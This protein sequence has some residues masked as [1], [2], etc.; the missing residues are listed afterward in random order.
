MLRVG[1]SRE[2]V[3]RCREAA[4]G[5]VLCLLGLLSVACQTASPTP[6][7]TPTPTATL[8][9]THTQSPTPTN[10]PPPTAT[11]TPG[12][13]QTPTPTPGPLTEAEAIALVKEE[14]VAHGVDL[15]T[16]N[17]TIAG[18]P[19]SVSI[20]YA[21]AYAV[22][23][24]AFEP[25]TVLVALAAARTLVRVQPPIIGG[26]R[27]AVRPEGENEVGLR[28]IVIDW[29]SLEAWASGSISDQDFV[30]LWTVGAVTR[31]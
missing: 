21:S 7:I 31:E 23:S 1:E 18:E 2:G 8:S 20:R 11:L 13:T 15:D 5:A 17:I 16:T 12:P 24:R 25:Q 27:L 4:V 9:P 19:R 6:T 14:L 29:S 22:D 10:T 26:I 30:S 3:C 28:V